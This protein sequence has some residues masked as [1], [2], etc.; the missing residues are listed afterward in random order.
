MN[1][2]IGTPVNEYTPW[3]QHGETELQ[4]YHR[5]CLERGAEIASLERER[6]E[7]LLKIEDLSCER[8]DAE[9]QH[10]KVIC[11]VISDN[12]EGER[13]Y[14]YLAAH[15]LGVQFPSVSHADIDRAIGI[16]NTLR[17]ENEKLKAEHETYA[18][19]VCGLL[20]SNATR[21]KEQ[22]RT[23]ASLRASLKGKVEAG[24]L[25]QWRDRIY[26][27]ERAKWLKV[28][29]QPRLIG[30]DYLYVTEKVDIRTDDLLDH[31]SARAQRT[32]QEGK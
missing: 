12:D 20:E 25:A 21:M 22:A 1:E 15:I 23:I 3:V 26:Q 29:G 14:G 19:T 10:R 27:R 5:I 24:K 7:L 11:Q 17:E 13:L 2:A 31:I 30:D 32:T 16:I 6:D 28:S 9:E 18:D 8:E 4:Y